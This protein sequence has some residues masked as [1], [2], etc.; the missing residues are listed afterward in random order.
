MDNYQKN[1]VLKLDTVNT[2]YQADDLMKVAKRDNNTKRPYLLVNPLQGKHIPVA[3]SAAFSMFSAL[4]NQLKTVYKDKKLLIIGFA[5]TATAIGAYLACSALEETYYIHTT[6]ESLNHAAYLYFTE[7][8]SHATEQKLVS[9]QLE[10]YIKKSDCILFAED[11]VTTGN[12]IMQLIALLQKHYSS[13][14]R[15]YGILSLLNSME[16]DRLQQLKNQGIMITYLCQLKN[17][18]YTSL[19][20]QYTFPSAL[21][22]AAK[23][24]PLSAV[25]IQELSVPAYYNPRV[26][27]EAS[28]YFSCCKQLGL[29]ILSQLDISAWT[30]KKIAVIGTEEFMF[31]ALLFASLLEEQIAESQVFFHATTRSPILPSKDL[32]YPLF[33]RYEL[34]SVY[35]NTRTTYLYNLSH[36]DYVFVLS[37]F[38]QTDFEQTAEKNLGIRHLISA[39]YQYDCTNFILCHYK[40]EQER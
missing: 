15:T 9:N 11:E 5:E 12:T 30:G 29:W 6:R 40:F 28:S 31:P 4:S 2:I 1:A 17:L 19:L 27:V 26:G 39:F 38:E 13:Y 14:K 24:V 7:S 35:D 16:E 36:Y 18:D 32:N 22:K 23:E 3:P 8:H 33:I 20:S 25:S 34:A 21:R 37:D 10:Q